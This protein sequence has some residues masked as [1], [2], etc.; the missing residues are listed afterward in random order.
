MAG[1]MIGGVSSRPAGVRRCDRDVRSRSCSS[2]DGRERRTDRTGDRPGAD[3]RPI[4]HTERGE[5]ASSHVL[6]G[7]RHL[8][9]SSQPDR[10]ARRHRQSA[11]TMRHNACSR[12]VRDP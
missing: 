7:T 5:S 3:A 10:G 2:S 8:E 11:A 1:T 9:P 12:S 6:V 4:L